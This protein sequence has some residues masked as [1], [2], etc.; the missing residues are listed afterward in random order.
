MNILYGESA[1]TVETTP[2]I[3]ETIRVNYDGV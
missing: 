3:T 1:T 2:V